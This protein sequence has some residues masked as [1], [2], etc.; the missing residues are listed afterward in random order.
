MQDDGD[1]VPLDSLSRY[2]SKVY[3][4]A[5][6]YFLSKFESFVILIT[7]CPPYLYL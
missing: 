5:Q 4:N 3:F 7:S 6:T 1:P 2:L